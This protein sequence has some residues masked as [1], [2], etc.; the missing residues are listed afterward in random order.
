MKKQLSM[1]TLAFSLFGLFISQPLLANNSAQTEAIFQ[2]YM[3]VVDEKAD[4]FDLYDQLNQIKHPSSLILALKGSTL[5]LMGRDAWMPWNKMAY[6]ERGMDVLEKAVDILDA[7][8]QTQTFREIPYA[9]H[10]KW[11][12]TSTF[13]SLPE[14]FGGKSQGQAWMA[15]MHQ[16]DWQ[17]LPQ[18]FQAS[19]YGINYQFAEPSDK[20]AWADKL[21][22]LE[23]QEIEVLEAQ[24]K[25]KQQMANQ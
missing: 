24:Q 9:A 4:A 21:M 10:V 15:E 5:T 8:D 7:V 20:Q 3:K 12:A 1:F 11:I 17:N 2:T 19:Y 18:G 22:A 6:V 23:S 13:L 25:L 16:L 14:F